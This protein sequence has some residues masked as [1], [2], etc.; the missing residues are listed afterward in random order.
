[1]ANEEQTRILQ[2]VAGGQIAPAEASDLL[3]ALTPVPAPPKPSPI[4]TPALT[5]SSRP[6]SSRCLTIQVLEG[7][8]SK[9]NV[10]IPLAL[11]RAA[12][13]FLPRQAQQYLREQGIEISEMLEGVQGNEDS[14]TLLEVEEEDK[15][16][17][18][19][20]E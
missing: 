7:D 15:R 20:I 2:M 13:R 4:S 14:T 8:H 5:F 16:V 11:A 17:R 3:A 10:R 6:G 18:I 19:A 12:E 9:V 1:M